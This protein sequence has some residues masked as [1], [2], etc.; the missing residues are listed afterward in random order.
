MGKFHFKRVG[1]LGF[2]ERMGKSHSVKWK[3]DNSDKE[4]KETSDVV[5][6]KTLERLPG[7]GFTFNKLV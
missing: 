1:W 3:I 7:K 2:W 5:A 6:I 4:T